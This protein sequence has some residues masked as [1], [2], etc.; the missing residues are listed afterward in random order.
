M[1]NINYDLLKMLHSKL[2]NVWRIEKHYLKDAEET[3]CQ[4]CIETWKKILEDEKKHVEMLKNKIEKKIV[5]N[6][7]D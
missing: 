1:K 5:E 3:K 7:F 4:H 6:K 2:D